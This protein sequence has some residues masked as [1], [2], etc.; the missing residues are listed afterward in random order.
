MAKVRL[1]GLARG[2]LRKEA[3]YLRQRSQPAAEA[4]LARM[5]E[6]RRSLGKFPQIGFEQEGLPVSGNRSLV[7]GDYVLDYDL[8]GEDVYITAIRPGQKPEVTV[9]V[10]EDFDYEEKESPPSPGS[11]R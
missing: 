6:A 2:Y 8:H 9:E 11:K 4:F 10:N 1:S 3:H 5:K 7:V